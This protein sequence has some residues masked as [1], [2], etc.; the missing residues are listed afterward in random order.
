MNFVIGYSVWNRRD[1]L[2]WL[3]DGIYD[4]FTPNDTEVVFHFD[5]C[6]DESDRVF[7]SL[8]KSW[9]VD[10]ENG[11]PASKIHTLISTSEVREVG[12]HNR[13]LDWWMTGQP[14]DDSL[15]IIAQDDQRFTAN[16]RPHLEALYAKYGRRLG[17]IGGRDGYG[18]G[19]SNFTGSMWSE[20][21]VERRLS[22]GEFAERPYQNSGP[23]VYNPTLVKT[24]GLLDEE[25]RA[26]YVWDDYGHRAL[27]NGFV[28]GVMGMDLIHRKFGIC[29]AT[30]WTDWSG[31]DMARRQMKHGF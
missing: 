5:A 9:L 14:T 1:M 6:T 20:S 15:C 26:Y 31:H 16:V 17:L 10:R 3:L 12:G 30:E 23:N 22:H 24:I 28:S 2:S 4:T 13:I 19:Y 21:A 25:F 7:P 29:K 18:V 11:W 27:K 8:A